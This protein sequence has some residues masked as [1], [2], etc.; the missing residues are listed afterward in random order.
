MQK[1]TKQLAIVLLIT[2]VSLVQP[3]TISAQSKQHLKEAAKEALHAM[4]KLQKNGGWAMAW[5]TDGSATYGEWLLREDDIITI[6][7]PGT[8]A[9]GS[10]FLKA[11]EVF[12]DSSYLQTAIHAGDALLQGQFSH[13]GFPQEF[14]AGR[15]SQNPEWFHSYDS[16]GSAWYPP[17]IEGADI[18]IDEDGSGTFDDGTTQSAALFLLELGQKTK[19]SRYNDAAKKAAGFMLKAQYPNGGWPQKYPLQENYTRFIT[20]NDEAMPRVMSSLFTFSEVWGDSIYYKAAIRGADYLINIQ[21]K[22]K[23]R[24]WA[25]QYTLDGEPVGARPWEPAALSAAETVGVA[26]FLIEVYLATGDKKYLESGM[27]AIEWLNKIRLSNEKWARFYDPETNKEVYMGG[28]GNI[29][30]DL[31]EALRYHSGYSWQGDYLDS[32]FIDQFH[33]LLEGNVEDRFEIY[34]DSK[35]E[36]E[37]D[38]FQKIST[39]LSEQKQKGLWTK[40]MSGEALDFYQIKFGHQKEIPEIIDAEDFVNNVNLILKFLESQPHNLKST[41]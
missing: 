8:P 40:Q 28:D 12:G 3:V 38:I 14:Y 22:H 29:T 9:I 39:V 11:F 6:Q 7:P 25:Q 19:L 41:H 36:S 27:V 32:A 30:S 17:D 35:K 1:L 26:E 5:A 10:V 18:Y 15:F 4:E 2:G 23:K 16:S 33:L 13:G 31:D 24:G 37:D 34:A 21:T 20:L